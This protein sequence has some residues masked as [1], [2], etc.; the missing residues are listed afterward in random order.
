MIIK[1]AGIILIVSPCY[2]LYLLKSRIHFKSFSSL[3]GFVSALPHFLSIIVGCFLI[4]TDSD[5]LE[6]LSHSKLFLALLIPLFLSYILKSYY[7]NR[8]RKKLLF[9]ILYF[10]A[11]IYC[12]VEI[13][14]AEWLF[15]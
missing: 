1:I 14:T 10:L 4:V 9:N 11:I 3:I 15:G 8:F 5:S 6:K 7:L 12:F 13:L 2:N